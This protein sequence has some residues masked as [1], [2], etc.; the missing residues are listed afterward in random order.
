MITKAKAKKLAQE[1]LF[2]EYGFQPTLKDIK[3]IEFSD[4]AMD[5]EIIMWFEVNHNGYEFSSVIDE[6]GDIYTGEGT[7]FKEKNNKSWK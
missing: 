3:N 7:I 1:A 5:Y 4:C 6:D 2:L